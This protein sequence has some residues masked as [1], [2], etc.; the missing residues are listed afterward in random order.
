MPFIPLPF[1][2]A[3]LLTL[4]FVHVIRRDEEGVRNGPFL[5]LILLSVFQSILSGLRWG[6]GVTAVMY[7]APVGAAMVPP[8]AYAGV[9]RLVRQSRAPVTRRLLLH[10][11]PALIIVVL[12]LFGRE[13]IDLVLVA[14]FVGYA[15]AILLL[16]GK[17]ADALKLA[18]FEGSARA[19]RAILFAAFALLFS[20][21]ID[22]LVFL[23]FAMAQ[24][25]YVR[26][27]VAVGNLALLAILSV[28]A[29]S[30]GAPVV[31]VEKAEPV[32]DAALPEDGQTLAAIES[33]MRV[34]RVYRDADL[35]L[36]RLARKAG[37]P[38]RQISAAINR[39]TGKNVSQY[40]NEQRIAEACALLEESDRPVTEIMFA[41]GFQTKSNFNREFRRVTD[42]TPLEW[43]AKRASLNAI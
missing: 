20:A 31:P 28:A 24:G 12:L 25:A 2:V 7:L 27:V 41:V 32:A 37:I 16:M 3:I 18:P 36:D 5:A 21:T 39:A 33:L 34:K 23:D 4:V 38:S 11:L 26:P 6:Y 19:Y 9:L 14:I 42:T 10:A 22:T 43:R 17:G 40:V 29:A 8:L 13:P 30:A 15:V 1:V 35:S